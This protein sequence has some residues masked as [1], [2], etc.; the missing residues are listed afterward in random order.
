MDVCSLEEWLDTEEVLL[1]FCV[2]E[3]WLGTEEDILEVDLGVLE[4]LLAFLLE[5]ALFFLPAPNSTEPV[6][7]KLKHLDGIGFMTSCIEG[8]WQLQ[9][10]VCRLK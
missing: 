1:G 10:F 4:E 3:E 2:L 6:G 5:V 9:G 8:Q 7:P